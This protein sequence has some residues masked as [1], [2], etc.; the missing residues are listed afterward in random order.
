MT[1]PAVSASAAPGPS[2]GLALT[3]NPPAV[4]AT[5]RRRAPGFWLQ[6]LG[7]WG[8]DGDRPGEQVVLP[9]ERLLSNMAWLRTAC[10]RY[11]VGIVSTPDLDS[12]LQQTRAQRRLLQAALSTPQPLDASEVA[13]R[14]TGT[15]FTGAPHLPDPRSRTPAGARERREFLRAGSRQDHRGLRRLRAGAPRGVLSRCSS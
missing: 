2:L 8:S 14:L 1:E 15:R 9:L 4:Q 11:G 6:L 7:E 12:I 5:R 10:Q 3:G 13:G